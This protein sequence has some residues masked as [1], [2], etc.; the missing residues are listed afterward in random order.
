[1]IIELFGP[2]CA[3]KTT[4]AVALAMKLRADGLKVTTRFSFRPGE[5]EDTAKA[6]MRANFS[7]LTRPAIELLSTNLPKDAHASALLGTLPRSNNLAALR[8]KQYLLR[9][10]ISWSEAVTSDCIA[11]FDQGY[12][13][14]VCSILLMNPALGDNAVGVLLTSLPQSDFLIRLDAAIGR[15]EARL[16]HRM[17][18]LGL[19]GRLFETSTA[20]VREQA[21]AAQR[22]SDMLVSVGRGMHIIRS[23]DQMSLDA[24]VYEAAT[25]IRARYAADAAP[26]QLAA[27]S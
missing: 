23:D 27:G 19:V 9:L 10:A 2:P 15:I 3:G 16:E 20:T 18:M 11:I 5:G 8:F 14:A 17:R 25:L 24:S 12:V 1:M 26:P 6:P 4:F 21:E 13:Q 7:R 22:V